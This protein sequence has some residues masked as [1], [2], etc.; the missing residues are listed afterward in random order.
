MKRRDILLLSKKLKIFKEYSKRRGQ[1]PGRANSDGGKKTQITGD[2]RRARE[3][4]R[5]PEKEDRDPQGEET[6]RKSEA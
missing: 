5:Q 1:R 3:K 6:Q 4:E 2:Q